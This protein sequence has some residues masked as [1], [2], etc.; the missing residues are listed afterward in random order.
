M[1]TILVGVI[2]GIIL[3]MLP[4]VSWETATLSEMAVCFLIYYSPVLL[5]KGRAGVE[6]DEFF[7]KLNTPIREEDKAEISAGYVKTIT[8]LFVFAMAVGGILFVAMSAPSA[9]TAGGK[10]GLVAGIACLISAVVLFLTYRLK[11]RI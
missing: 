9:A 4:S 11:K 10:Y 2:T 1:A 5:R 3:N 8:Y 7:R 6:H